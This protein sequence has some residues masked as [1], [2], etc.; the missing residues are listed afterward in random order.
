MSQHPI[1]RS[2]PSVF[3]ATGDRL[4]RVSAVAR[5]LHCTCRMVRYLAER[6]F[7]PAIKR[8]KLW[9]FRESDVEHYWSIHKEARYE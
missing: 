2:E 9:F 6:K 3:T 7:I 1:P 8:G 4:L 5:R